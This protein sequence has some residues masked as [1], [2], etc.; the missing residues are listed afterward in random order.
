MS[1]PSDAAPEVTN[2]VAPGLKE[3]NHLLRPAPGHGSIVLTKRQT[4]IPFYG[5]LRPPEARRK[6]KMSPLGCH[7]E[8]RYEA[9]P[10]KGCSVSSFTALLGPCESILT[11]TARLLRREEE[12]CS[13]S[14]II[15]L[16]SLSSYY[17]LCRL[18]NPSFLWRR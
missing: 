9:S 18:N 13:A 5:Y 2:L 3:H 1:F 6:K 12:H 14:C 4:F 16:S 17:L 7:K 11:K 8:P 15:A 10:L